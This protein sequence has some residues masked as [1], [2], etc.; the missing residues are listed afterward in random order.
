[1]MTQKKKSITDTTNER[2]QLLIL[3]ATLN[4]LGASLSLFTETTIT[5][6]PY[7]LT[8]RTCSPICLDSKEKECFFL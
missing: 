6:F 3:H 5:D 7:F 4:R 8:A 2:T 1:M